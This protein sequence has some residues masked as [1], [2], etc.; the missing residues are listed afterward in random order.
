M[1]KL[2]GHRYHV[3]SHG[4]K[5]T[6]ASPVEAGGPGQCTGRAR[7]SSAGPLRGPSTCPRQSF[8]VAHPPGS[9]PPP[10]P[11]ELRVSG[12]DPSG[13]VGNGWPG[14]PRW[15]WRFSPAPSPTL[16]WGGGKQQWSPS[17]LLHLRSLQ[18]GTGRET[19]CPSSVWWRGG[20]KGGS[21]CSGT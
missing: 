4:C 19:D 18:R 12:R 5:G 8:T 16:S 10:H 20:G 7:V 15:R 1:R 2:G 17:C 3:P 21:G 9:C 6:G 13:G 14:D 11:G